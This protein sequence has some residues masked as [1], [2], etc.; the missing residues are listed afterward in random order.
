[1][2]HPD[3]IQVDEVISK[4]FKNQVEHDPA[5]LST[6]RDLAERDDVIPIG[7]FYRDEYAERY[8][9][10]SMHGLGMSAAQK[11][12]EVQSEMDRFLI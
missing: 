3:G 2:K 7:L 5:D 11:V 1:M 4:Q 10:A 9:K 12:E 6:G 8:D